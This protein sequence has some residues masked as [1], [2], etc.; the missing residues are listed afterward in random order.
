MRIL[1]RKKV[2]VKAGGSRRTLLVPVTHIFVPS[3]AIPCGPFATNVPRFE[4]S[5]ARSF[6]T[7][8]PLV[9]VTQMLVPSNAIPLGLLPT[10]NV[11]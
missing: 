10:V 2:Q 11:P 7:L 5:L 6:V 4:P 3:N 1:N 8:L 9:F